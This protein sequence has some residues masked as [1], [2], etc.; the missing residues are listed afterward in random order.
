[1]KLLQILFVEAIR[2]L[3]VGLLERAGIEGQNGPFNF[4]VFQANLSRGEL[5]AVY[6]HL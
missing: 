5:L 3:V 1:M 6:V 4:S 2:L